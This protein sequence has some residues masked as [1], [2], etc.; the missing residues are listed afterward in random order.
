VIAECAGL[1]GIVEVD[2]LPV[3]RFCDLGVVKLD[4]IAPDRKEVL[5]V[6]FLQGGGELVNGTPRS[7]VALLMQAMLTAPP[8]PAWAAWM[9]VFMDASQLRMGKSTMARNGCIL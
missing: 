4:R 8:C 9:V 1:V 2:E 3:R 5:V 6:T 7:T